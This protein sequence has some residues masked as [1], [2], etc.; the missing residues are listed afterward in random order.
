MQNCEG[1][2]STR[3]KSRQIKAGG[4]YDFAED[5]ADSA[6]GRIPNGGFTSTKLRTGQPT[7]LHQ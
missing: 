2:V 3:H 7:P 6:S 5:S 4:T 1:D